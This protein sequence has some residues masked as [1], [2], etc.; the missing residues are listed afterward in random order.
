MPLSPT[1]ETDVRQYAIICGI[2]LALMFALKIP[3]LGVD[4]LEDDERIYWALAQ[5]WLATGAYSLR[6]TELLESLP[7]AM[8]DKPLFHHPPMQTFLLIPFAW[9]DTPRAAVMVS[10]LGH[11]AAVVGVA[12]ICWCARR[13][14]GGAT[15]LFLWLPVL[16]VAVDPILTLTARKI[17]PDNLAGGFCA[18]SAGFCFLAAYRGSAGPALVGGVFAAFAALSKLPGLL[19][20]PVGSAVLWFAVERGK[21]RAALIGG[22]V[23]PQIVLVGLWLFVFHREYGV[24]LPDWIMPDSALRAL[25]SH[26]ERAMQRPIWY[27]AGQTLLVAPVSGV[28]VVTMF[29]VRG[30]MPSR[31]LRIG[32]LWLVLGYVALMMLQIM[33]QGA[34]LRFLTPIAA[35]WYVCMYGVLRRADANRSLL[36]VTFLAAVLY[37][38]STAGFFLVQ[39]LAYDDIVSVPEMMWRQ[40]CG[41]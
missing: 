13:G 2:I 30:G 6:G 18:L 5:N 4:H 27:Y 28:I 17:W 34:Q 36:G 41:N 22:F 23:A 29:A 1:R 33:G 20:L 37:S 25:S 26:V 10:W 35:G 8:Y 14:H 21:H 12:L 32:L 9:L 24:F 31:V 7:P 19:A 39:G 38:V 16:G 11:A 40:F 3:S 15:Q